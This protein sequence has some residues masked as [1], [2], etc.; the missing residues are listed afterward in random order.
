MDDVAHTSRYSRGKI[1]PHHWKVSSRRFVVAL[2]IS[3]SCLST[4]AGCSLFVLAGKMFFGDPLY[5]SRVENLTDTD[6]RKTG[7]PLILVCSVPQSVKDQLPSLEF[8]IVEGVSRKLRTRGLQL[9]SSDDVATWVDDR[10][11]MWNDPHELARDFKDRAGFIGHI[12]LHQYTF[13]PDNSPSM[14]QGNVQG[15]ITVYEINEESDVLPSQQIFEENFSLI[16]PEHA[17]T[18]AEEMP[19]NVFQQKLIQRVS[20]Q[21]GFYFHK[22]RQSEVLE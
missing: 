17:P 20:K 12:D 18:N 15:T 13:H 8:D 5:P 11:G 1:G 9:V 22:Y 16:W 21:I 7:K 4:M 19:L 3:I 10:G 2:L 6:I 14:L